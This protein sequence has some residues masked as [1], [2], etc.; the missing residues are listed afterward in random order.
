MQYR[1]DTQNVYYNGSTVRSNR[2]YTPAWAGQRAKYLLSYLLSLIG[3]Q[4]SDTEQTATGDQERLLM[5]GRPSTMY[6][7]AKLNFTQEI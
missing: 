1:L 3:D 6:R 4:F 5:N 2:I 7:V